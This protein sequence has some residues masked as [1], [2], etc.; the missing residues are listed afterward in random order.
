VTLGGRIRLL[1]TT[2][3][4]VGVAIV[5]LL[6]VPSVPAARTQGDPVS[7]TAQWVQGPGANQQTLTVKNTGGYVISEFTFTTDDNGVVFVA[8]KGSP[9]PCSQGSSPNQ[10]LCGSQVGPGTTEKVVMTSQNPI[11]TGA[12]GNIEVYND[13]DQA[14]APATETLKSAPTERLT[15]TKTIV[16]GDRVGTEEYDQ[17]TPLTFEIAVHNPSSTRVNAITVSDRAWIGGSGKPATF[18]AHMVIPPGCSLGGSFFDDDLFECRGVSIPPY[19]TRTF[20]VTMKFKSR[21]AGE[22]AANW[23][24]AQ[25]GNRYKIPGV[26]RFHLVHRADR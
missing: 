7:Y 21:T 25:V 5:V 8:I 12:S 22:N 24:Y 3:L 10:A 2:A 11:P 13:A 9:S 6:L 23:A 20:R 16:A 15:V 26:V 19:G 1:L 18:L 17:D 4:G 14:Q